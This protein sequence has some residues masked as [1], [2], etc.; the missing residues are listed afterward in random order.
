MGGGSQTGRWTG[1][2]AEAQAGL[3]HVIALLTTPSPARLAEAA[4][5][6]A[7]AIA[8]A[9]N[10]RGLAEAASAPQRGEL[11]CLRTLVGRATVLLTKAGL[12]HAGWMACLGALTGGYRADGAPARVSWSGRF[13]ASG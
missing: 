2:I 7:S 4:G 10:W 6:L 11:A 9:Q 13:A 1:E 12:Y 8:Q 3:R 5:L